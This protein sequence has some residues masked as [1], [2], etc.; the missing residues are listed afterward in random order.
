MTPT[1]L[2]FILCDRVRVDPNNLQRI[3]IEG[4]RTSIRSKHVPPFPCP[5]PLLTTLA[6]FMGGTG[7]GE[8]STRIVDDTGQLVSASVKPQRVKFVGDLRAIKGVKILL[9]NCTFPR[10][11]L[12]WVELLFS[13]KVIARQPMS[14]IS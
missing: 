3:N 7:S 5:V 10:Q 13:G 2:Y 14:V 12:Y 1:V 9:P 11:D 4:L 8:L 6:I